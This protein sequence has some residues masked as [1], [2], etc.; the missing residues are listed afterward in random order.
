MQPA[1]ALTAPADEFT[2]SSPAAPVG[3]STLVHAPA[4]ITT[5][6]NSPATLTLSVADPGASR[7]SKH[8][9]TDAAEPA[10]PGIAQDFYKSAALGSPSDRLDNVPSVPV[11]KPDVSDPSNIAPDVTSSKD[12]KPDPSDPSNSL[13]VLGPPLA[14]KESLV[15]V[16]SRGAEIGATTC[17]TGSVAHIICQDLS[18][19]PGV[20]PASDSIYT[21]LLPSTP[22]PNLPPVNGKSIARVPNPALVFA[23]ST[24]APGNQATIFGS[25]VSVG[26]SDAVKNGS[27]YTI[28]KHTAENA[29]LFPFTLA[30]EIVARPD[31][32]PNEVQT[33]DEIISVHEPATTFSRAAVSLAPSELYIG[34]SVLPFPTETTNRTPGS[35][36]LVMNASRSGP[37]PAGNVSSGA[38]AVV[39]TDGAWRSSHF[40]CIIVLVFMTAMVAM[41]D[42]AL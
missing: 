19:E 7:T 11:G 1:T 23:S 42:L 35:G 14:I 27:K 40:H 34:S 26:F 17:T 15:R 4:T 6:T 21:P 18:T 28:S 9:N 31:G 41:V 38:N 20:V 2:P 10:D 5:A 33:S 39:F 30:K 24:I 3:R 16:S 37:S 8:A 36:D 29:Q 25:I 22:T 12:G 13:S 32:N